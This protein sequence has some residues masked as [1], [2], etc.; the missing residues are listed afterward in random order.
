MNYYNLLNDFNVNSTRMNELNNYQKHV[1]KMFHYLDYSFDMLKQNKYMDEEDVQED[2]EQ[3][4]ESLEH[5]KQ[6]KHTEQDEC[7]SE[8]EYDEECDLV[9]LENAKSIFI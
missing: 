2:I 1:G 8:E 9:P 5:D 3:E 7:D 4:D 6:D